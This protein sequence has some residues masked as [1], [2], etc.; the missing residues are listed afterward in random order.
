VSPVD[1]GTPPGGP[2]RPCSVIACATG[3]WSG[4]V[5]GARARRTTALAGRR[6]TDGEPHALPHH[7]AQAQGERAEEC[8]ARPWERKFL[9]FSFTSGRVP[10]RRIAP[11]AVLRFQ[12]KVRELTHPRHVHPQALFL[13]HHQGPLP[14]GG[15]GL[16]RVRELAPS[17]SRELLES[18]SACHSEEP[19]ATT[20][21]VFHHYGA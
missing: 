20:N 3:S 4:E 13:R 8:G 1:E 19:E 9:G 12:A 2:C 16:G 7:E 11:K 6:A 5:F 15:R 18:S 14:Q 21:L 17:D 10:K